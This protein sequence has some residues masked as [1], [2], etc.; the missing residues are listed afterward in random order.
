MTVKVL[1]DVKSIA[2]YPIAYYKSRA[3]EEPNDC[4]TIVV[5]EGDNKNSFS[6]ISLN[7]QEGPIKENGENGCQIDVLI[8]IAKTMIS[9]LNDQF[10]ASHNTKAIGHL[11][12]A[13]A[14]LQK[15][16]EDRERR[17]VEGYNKA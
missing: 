11:E 1:K 8:H 17:G 9:K 13:L 6:S 12:L 4:K 16:K 15:R 5:F 7:I 10:S 3:E 14:A 2:G